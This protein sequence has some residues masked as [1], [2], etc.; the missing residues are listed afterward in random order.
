ML[1]DALLPEFDHEMAATRKVL[2]RVPEDKLTWRPHDRS[3]SLGELA[4]HVANL[5]TWGTETILKAEI[6]LAGGQPLNPLGS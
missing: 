4:T 6:D 1:V 3:F 2:E 5:P